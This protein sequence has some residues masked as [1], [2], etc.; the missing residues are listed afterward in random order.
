MGDLQGGSGNAS[1]AGANSIVE[2]KGPYIERDRK[3]WVFLLHAVFDEP[4]EKQMHSLSLR[5]IN[6]RIRAGTITRLNGNG[7]DLPMIPRNPARP[8]W[9]FAKSRESLR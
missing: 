3:L 4:G 6:A 9:A 5:E 8:S 1:R 2:V 7:G